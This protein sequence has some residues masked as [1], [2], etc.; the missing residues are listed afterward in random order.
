M[1]KEDIY[2]YCEKQVAFLLT[3]FQRL[4]KPNNDKI[5]EIF[6]QVYAYNKVMNFISLIKN[7]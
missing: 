4:D 2:D 3:Y 7:K 1:T 5:N 6:W